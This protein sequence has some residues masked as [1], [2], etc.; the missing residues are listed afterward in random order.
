MR[1]IKLLFDYWLQDL[2]TELCVHFYL[3]V[4]GEL[5]KCRSGIFLNITTSLSLPFYWVDRHCGTFF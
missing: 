5:V 4:E 3:F 1:R 2:K